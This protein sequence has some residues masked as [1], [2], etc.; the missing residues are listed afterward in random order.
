MKNNFVN[1]SICT[2]KFNH[3]AA[4]FEEKWDTKMG[5]GWTD[6]FPTHFLTLARYPINFCPLLLYCKYRSITASYSNFAPNTGVDV[7]WPEKNQQVGSF[8]LFTNVI[9]ILSKKTIDECLTIRIKN[10]HSSVQ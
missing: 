9:E 6:A 10:N 8:M 3:F 2:K 5:V 1:G 4:D 7:D